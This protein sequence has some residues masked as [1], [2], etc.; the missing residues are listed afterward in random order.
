MRREIRR[1]GRPRISSRQGRGE[2]EDAS[3]PDKAGFVP[4][5]ADPSSETFE[6]GE[7]LFTAVCEIG[8]AGVVAK[9]LTSRY[10]PNRRGWIKTKN[11]NS[12]RLDLEREAMQRSRERRARKS[13]RR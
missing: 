13:V 7:A 4:P 5:W 9:R 8:L 2:A 3:R 6:D 10:G 1:P 12:W 11:P